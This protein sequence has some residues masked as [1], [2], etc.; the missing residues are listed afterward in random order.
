[1]RTW[2]LR[3]HIAWPA[4]SLVIALLLATMVGNSTE[5]AK[6]QGSVG[7]SYFLK[8]EGIEGDSIVDGHAGE[9]QIE[10]WS[11][12]ES[13]SS[14]ALSTS[15]GLGAGK[16]KMNDFHF[17]M[18]SSKATPKLFLACAQGQVLKSAVL[19]G[20][21]NTGE[22]FLKWELK[23]VLVSSFETGDKPTEQAVPTDQFSMN[24]AKIIVE[25]TAQKAD[26]SLEVVRAGWD[27]GKQKGI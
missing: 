12:G 2:A 22:T 19:I 11:W 20:V 13:N 9:L 17:T 16:V 27:L 15:G 6:A 21:R 25:Y 10:S 7:V 4:A 8:I 18:K 14:N 24:F 23:N 5:E 26:G 1:M 3:R